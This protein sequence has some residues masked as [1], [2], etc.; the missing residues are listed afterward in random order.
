M[1]VLIKQIESKKKDIFTDYYPMSIGELV[2]LYRDGHIDISPYF[3]RFFR[4]TEEQKVDL[5]ESIFLGIPLPSLFIS[6]RE[7]SVWEL[8]DGLQRVSTI[9]SFMNELKDED[10]NKKTPLI[11]YVTKKLPALRDVSWNGSE[12]TTELDSSLKIAFKRSKLDIKILKI[13][14][15][16]DNKFELF[17][18]LNIGNN[19]LSTQE[20]RN[21]LL[22]MLDPDA[23]KRLAKVS[24]DDLFKKSIAIGDCLYDQLY[25]MELIIRLLFLANSELEDIKKITDISSYL[26]N[27]ISRLTHAAFDWDS[28]EKLL[29]NTFKLIGDVLGE[30][31]FN[32]YDRNSDSFKGGFQITYFELIATGAYLLLKQKKDEKMIKE[33]VLNV[34]KAA[35]YDNILNQYS[36]SDSKVSYRWPRV[37]EHVRENFANEIKK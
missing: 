31:A 27:N 35:P 30:N 6:Q 28:E 4:W 8:V 23:Y 14:N 20:V 33:L 11:L 34:A 16:E 10:G 15:D 7:D 26:T 32:K 17:K 3:Q 21:C 19:E 22:I 13:E 1:D 9:L 37:Y 36:G 24:E 2:H 18:R 29:K 12:E 5:I 25:N